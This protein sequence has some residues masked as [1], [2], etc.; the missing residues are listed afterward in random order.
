MFNV[1]CVCVFFY[2]VYPR[3]QAQGH[4]AWW[5]VPLPTETTATNTNFYK[6]FEELKVSC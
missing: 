3:D 2:L 5:Q 6:Y 1:V 4:Q